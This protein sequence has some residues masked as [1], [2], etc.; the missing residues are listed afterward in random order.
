MANYFRKT[1]EKMINVVDKMDSMDNQQLTFKFDID[2]L[3]AHS[4]NHGDSINRALASIAK[5]SVD[6]VHLA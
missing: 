2:K 4:N 3:L 6:T 1:E 5:L